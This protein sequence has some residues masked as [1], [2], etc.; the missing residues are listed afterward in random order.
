[1]NQKLLP[2]LL[3]CLIALVGNTA[4]TL[5]CIVGDARN[6][7]NNLSESQDIGAIQDATNG[8]VK[9]YYDP[10]DINVDG[11]LRGGYYDKNARDSD[12]HGV[13]L[14]AAGGTATDTENF[15]N[16]WG[17]KGAH[18][19]T[20][21]K[22]VANSVGWFANTMWGVTNFLN[23]TSVNT[24]G[25]YNQSPASSGNWAINQINKPLSNQILVNNTI[26]TWNISDD[27]K[28][29]GPAPRPVPRPVV[30]PGQNMN[31][32]PVFGNT[33]PANYRGTGR[34][35]D[36]TVL[37]NVGSDRP[38]S[39]PI[40]RSGNPMNVSNNTS[41]T[42]NCRQFSSHAID[43]MQSDGIMPS[44]V[45]NALSHYSP[46]PGNRPGTS[47]HFD[48]INNLSVVVNSNNGRVITV[49]KGQL[50]IGK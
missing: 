16:M 25:Q 15:I 49:S 12:V 29:N 34:P 24:S 37:T 22:D 42:I 27:D 5:E 38:A 46:Q 43:Q 17:A 23:G 13:Y 20:D 30:R 10:F 45:A 14:N 28:L 2:F 1:M 19:H 21:N 18:A 3:G 47:V 48:P 6:T 7:L 4:I 11:E 8:D 35:G 32:H 50:V 40:G 41:T 31:P 44:V 39:T 26:D 9:I 33:I 36:P